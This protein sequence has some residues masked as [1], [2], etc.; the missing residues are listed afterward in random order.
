ML[1]E[2]NGYDLNVLI[3]AKMAGHRKNNGSGTLIRV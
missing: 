1:V 3:I 2:V